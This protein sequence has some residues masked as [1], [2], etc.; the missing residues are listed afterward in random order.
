[1]QRTE[2]GLIKS[3]PSQQ[4]SKYVIQEKFLNFPPCQWFNLQGGATDR[5]QSAA[6]R[7][8]HGYLPPHSRFQLRLVKLIFSPANSLQSIRT[9]SS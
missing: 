3:Q 7:G 5:T 1:M 4:L 8:T 6:P 9:V 2:F